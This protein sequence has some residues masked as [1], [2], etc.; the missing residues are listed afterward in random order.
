ME[1]LKYTL[2][3][4][5]C[6]SYY[7]TINKKL[8]TCLQ[9]AHNKCKRFCLKLN[10]ISSIKSKDF[11]RKWLPTLETVSQCSLCSICSFLLRVVLFW[12]DICS[13]R[14]WWSSYVF[15]IPEMFLVKKQM[16]DKKLYL[17][18]V[19]HLGNNLNNTLKTWTSLNAF[20]QN[21]ILVNYFNELKKKESQ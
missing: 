14:N 2:F 18:L 16:L 9:D 19:L 17:M 21:I 5:A 12:W 15:I 10:D 1:V 11:K 6:N 13:C 20:K 8:K 3:D 4:N 7:P